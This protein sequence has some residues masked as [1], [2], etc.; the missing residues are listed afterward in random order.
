[1]INLKRNSTTHVCLLYMKMKKTWITKKDI[2]A[3][4]PSKFKQEYVI[5]RSLDRL[6]SQGLA[7]SINNSYH[8]TPS[9][10]LAVTQIAQQQSR[11][12]NE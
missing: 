2:L 4:A 11:S 1:M 8:I 7:T 12:S 10:L 9:G 3:F 6:I 5:Q